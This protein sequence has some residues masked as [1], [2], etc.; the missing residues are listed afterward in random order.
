MPKHFNNLSNAVCP[1]VVKPVNLSSSKGVRYV[2]S[3]FEKKYLIIKNEDLILQE[4]IN[5]VGCGYSFFSRDG[6]IICGSGHLRLAE[7][8]VTGGSSVYRQTFFLEQMKSIVTKIV[9]SINY[10][11]FAMFEFKL[12][13]DGQ[14]FLLEVN[15][16]IWGSI[17]QGLTNGVNYFESILGSASKPIKRKNLNT[18]LSPLLYIS[19]FEYIIKGNFKPMLKFITNFYRN[20]P[21]ISPIKDPLG[22]LSI[23]IR[24]IV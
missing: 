21:D 16:R 2:L 19:F 9:G 14:L 17:N 22:Y 11:G 13:A 4:Y 1:F 7:Y 10:S 6:K 3:E 5:G 15:P 23:I 24:K 20:K 12:Q 8:P 18:Y